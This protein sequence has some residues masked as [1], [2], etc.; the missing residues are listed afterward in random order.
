MT[1]RLLREITFHHRPTPSFV[2]PV[3]PDGVA[4]RVLDLDD[5]GAEVAE[6]RR[7]QRS[8]EQRRHVE[9]TEA[10]ERRGWFGRHS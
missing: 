6:H 8:G 4:A 10:F 9:D 5:V 2:A 1:A 7:G 3:Q